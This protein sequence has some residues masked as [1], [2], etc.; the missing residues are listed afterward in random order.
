MAGDIQRGTSSVTPTQ[1][2]EAANAF[3]RGSA[4]ATNLI[5]AD[6]LPRL[7]HTVLEFAVARDKALPRD[8]DAA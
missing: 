1:R 2:L 7:M 8:F 6:T 5:S 3:R 4:T